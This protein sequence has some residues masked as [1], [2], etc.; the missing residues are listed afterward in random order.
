MSNVDVGAFYLYDDG[1]LNPFS[2]IGLPSKEININEGS[3]YRKAKDKRE[4][5]EMQFEEN[6]PILKTGITEL[7]ISYLY[8][9]PI[10]YNNEIIAILELASV[11]KPKVDIKKYLNKILSDTSFIIPAIPITR[12]GNP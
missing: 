7:K 3:F 1:K 4:I 2:V 10:F 11:N 8:I 9:L 5:V 6:H 12:I